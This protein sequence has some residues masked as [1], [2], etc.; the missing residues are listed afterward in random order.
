VAA[1]ARQNATP[2][3]EHFYK[4]NESFLNIPQYMAHNESREV[5]F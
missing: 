4:G 5:K 3:E 2:P 1:F